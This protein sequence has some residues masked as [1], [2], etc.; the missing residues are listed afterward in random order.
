MS[1][2][3]VITRFFNRRAD[4]ILCNVREGVI[5]NKAGGFLEKLQR[6]EYI[7]LSEEADRTGDDARLVASL[8]MNWTWAAY[9]GKENVASSEQ[10][11]TRFEGRGYKPVSD[12]SRTELEK[13]SPKQ[14]LVCEALEDIK[15]NGA[16]GA[17][18]GVKLRTLEE[19]GELYAGTVTSAP[20]P[21]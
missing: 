20:E 9:D 14:L 17:D 3:G 13:L 19:A 1:L 8:I 11:I 15:V 21:R 18:L 6:E 12:L 4:G 10:F 16:L 5:D 2:L 7:R